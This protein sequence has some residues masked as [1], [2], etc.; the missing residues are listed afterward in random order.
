MWEPAKTAGCK[1][2][3]PNDTGSPA[4]IL[5]LDPHESKN[6]LGVRDCPDG[7]N[8]SHLKHV[9]YKVNT[10]IGKLRS[11]HLQSSIGWIAYKLQRWPGVRYDIGAV[12]ND[13]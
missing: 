5:S 6:T 4:P 9:R 8:N 10:W 1:I 7:R 2:L 13:L 11:G 12:T 3:I